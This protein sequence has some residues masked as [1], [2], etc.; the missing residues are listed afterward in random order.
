[1]PRFAAILETDLRNGQHENPSSHPLWFTTSYFHTP[2]EIPEELRSA[3]LTDISVLPVE[4]FT[5]VTGVPASLRAEAGMATVLNH[6]RVTEREPALLGVSSHLLS[7][8]RKG[9]A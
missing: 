6:L 3:G 9:V 4:G 5:S 1:M 7:I 8:S 2:T